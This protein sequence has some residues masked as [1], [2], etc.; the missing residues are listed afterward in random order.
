MTDPSPIYVTPPDIP[1]GLT[2]AEYRQSRPARAPWWR[3]PLLR[4]D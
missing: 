2:I 1:P 3:R 4:R